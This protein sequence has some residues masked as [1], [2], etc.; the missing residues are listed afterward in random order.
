MFNQ[1]RQNSNALIGKDVFRIINFMERNQYQYTDE[2]IKY[3]D[4]QDHLAILQ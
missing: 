2:D 3:G 1:L 4:N